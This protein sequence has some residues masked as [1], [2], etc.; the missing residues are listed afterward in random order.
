[1]HEQR[2]LL[3]R[4]VRV[5]PEQTVTKSV[6]QFL[7]STGTDEAGVQ[8]RASESGKSRKQRWRPGGDF[9]FEDSRVS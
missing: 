9:D 3:A 7:G 5:L 8:E 1:M 2:I 4:C 6:I